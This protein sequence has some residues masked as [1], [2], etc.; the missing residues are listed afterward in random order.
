MGGSEI[1][2][3]NPEKANSSKEAEKKLPEV[4]KYWTVLTQGSN[5]GRDEWQGDK[6]TLLDKD[7]FTKQGSPLRSNA[8]LSGQVWERNHPESA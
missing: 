2:I 7:T 5:L 8:I 4:P 1:P 6:R 3:N